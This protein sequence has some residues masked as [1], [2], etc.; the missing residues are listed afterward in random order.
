[1][2]TTSTSATKKLI[3]LILI[4]V[5]LYFGKDFLM[6]LAIGGILATLFLPLCKW[7]EGRK[8]YKGIA[9]LTCLLLLLLVIVIVISL[10]GWEIADLNKNSALMKQKTI[11]TA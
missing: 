8:I 2:T 3:I 4:L 7:L 10:L 9:A 6:P 1:M 5:L 11:E